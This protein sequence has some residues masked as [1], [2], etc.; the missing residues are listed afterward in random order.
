MKSK[1][2]WKLASGYSSLSIVRR[3]VNF[4]FYLMYKFRKL[5][6]ARTMEQHDERPGLRLGLSYREEH[7]NKTMRRL[8]DISQYRLYKLMMITSETLDELGKARILSM[9]PRNEIELYMLVLNGFKWSMID[10]VD[11]VAS[12]N[13]ITPADFS[14]SLPFNDNEFDVVFASHALSKSYDRDTTC[15]EIK[16]ILKPG[17]LFA[18]ADN[19]TQYAAEDFA[20]DDAINVSGVSSGFPE[21]WHTVV[22]LYA[23]AD[24]QRVLYAQDIGQHSFECIV[25]V[26]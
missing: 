3:L 20:G 5:K 13:K 2:R 18:I 16:R 25:R 8:D 6:V 11:L 15:R 7:I 21:R 9:G 23:E 26:D 14:V 12:T 10:A 19:D 4:A 24:Y 22:R 1:I 17:G